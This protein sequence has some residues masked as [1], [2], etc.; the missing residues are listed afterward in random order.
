MWKNLWLTRR[1]KQEKAF[2]KDR[3][4]FDDVEEKKQYIKSEIELETDLFYKSLLA[5]SIFTS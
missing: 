2:N 1:Y 3:P 5:K 4:I